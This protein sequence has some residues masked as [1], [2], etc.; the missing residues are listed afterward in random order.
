MSLRDS[1]EKIALTA[2]NL[3]SVTKDLPLST[4]ENKVI[5]TL[6]I[7]LNDETI[8]MF[9]MPEKI[10]SYDM[11]I[12]KWSDENNYENVDQERSLSSAEVQ[13][14]IKNSAHFITKISI[15]TGFVHVHVESTQ[16]QPAILFWF[17]RDE[18]Y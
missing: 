15:Y 12:K 8:L 16:Q 11:V 14:L 3:L 6:N 10:G 18:P 1:A 5:S 2:L 7:T 9:S 17:E 13:Y 4:Q